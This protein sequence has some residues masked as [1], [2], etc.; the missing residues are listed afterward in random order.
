MLS[1][2]ISLF[3]DGIMMYRITVGVCEH[4]DETRLLMNVIIIE[5]GTLGFNILIL[6]I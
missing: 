4:M 3:M 5:A 2:G 1:N 6:S